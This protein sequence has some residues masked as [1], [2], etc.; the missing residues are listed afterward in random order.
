MRQPLAPA[1]ARFA[2]QAPSRV[3]ARGA[4]PVNSLSEETSAIVATD[5]L[6]SVQ[7]TLNKGKKIAA[8][9]KGL[10]LFCYKVGLAWSLFFPEQQ[11]E[12]PKE[13]VKKRL[14]MV[15]VAD[16][17]GMSPSSLSD[18][19]GSIIRALEDFVDIECEESIDVAISN[20][21]GVGTIYSVNIPVRRVKSEVCFSDI[22]AEIGEE[23]A[24]IEW[25]PED[26]ERKLTLASYSVL[27]C[28]VMSQTSLPVSNGSS[29]VG[30]R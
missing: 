21:P 17:C 22:L 16:R 23:R 12:S 20:D 6:Q 11:Y 19:K 18:M 3:G 7:Y 26:Y 28:L 1:T 4:G 14:R 10:D 2:P 15:L 27:Q 30:W 29:S 13:Q 5:V 9:K 24:S 8:T 25:S